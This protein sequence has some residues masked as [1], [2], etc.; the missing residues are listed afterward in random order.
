[1]S[2]ACQRLGVQPQTIYAYVSRGKLEVMA[3]PDNRRR[4]LYR[5]EDLVG[6]A[7]RKQTGRKR[8]TVAQDTLFGAQPSIPTSLTT[9]F[10]GRLYYRGRDAVGLARSATLEEVAQLLWDAQ[11]PVDFSSAAHA[12]L[13]RAPGRN[14]AFT[15]LASLAATAHS[16]RGRLLHVLQTEGQ[17]LVGMLANAFGAAPGNLPLHLRF[18]KAWKQS[19]AVADLIRAAMVLLADHE[20]TSSAFA[21]RIAASTG[22]SLPA[23]LLAGLST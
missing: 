14:A 6:L 5:A 3:D 10:R 15:A 11:Q 20:L 21:T 12:K 23:C 22:A 8:E 18:A 16:T 2:E 1:M 7:K 9:F 17:G 4:S 19:A 13:A